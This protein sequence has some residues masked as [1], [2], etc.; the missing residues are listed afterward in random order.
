MHKCLTRKPSVGG[1]GLS[2]GSRSYDS[3]QL[4][5]KL[6][7]EGKKRTI[8]PRA[9][10]LK[11]SMLHDPTT[12][13]PPCSRY[14]TVDYHTRTSCYV[15]TPHAWRVFRFSSNHHAADRYRAQK[16]FMESKISKVGPFTVPFVQIVCRKSQPCQNWAFIFTL[17]ALDDQ[18]TGIK[19]LGSLVWYTHLPTD[20]T[21]TNFVEK[22]EAGSI[23]YIWIEITPIF[24]LFLP[25]ELFIIISC[26]SNFSCANS[27]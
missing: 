6:V 24:Q 2:D 5:V 9:Y 15:N 3:G 22:E 7:G 13:V 18:S 11:F 8:G 17:R 20:G 12:T 4:S 21:I 19:N 10:K 26:G 16:S 1:C 25:S 14:T 23:T 27:W